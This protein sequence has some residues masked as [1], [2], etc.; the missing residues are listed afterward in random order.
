MRMFPVF[1]VLFPVCSHSRRNG[2]LVFPVFRVFWD[3]SVGVMLP[4]LPYIHQQGTLRTLR[5]GLKMHEFAVDQT[6]NRTRNTGNEFE[7]L[8]GPLNLVARPRRKEK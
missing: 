5:T 3:D 1:P 4:S 2:F 7:N 6:R 8:Y